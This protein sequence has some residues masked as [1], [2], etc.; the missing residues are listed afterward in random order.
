[1]LLWGVN[2]GPPLKLQPITGVEAFLKRLLDL[3]GQATDPRVQGIDGEWLP[4]TADPNAGYA[5]LF[6][7]ESQLPPHRVI[8]KLGDVQHHY[9][10]RTASNFDIASHIYLE[11]MFGRRPQPKLIVRVEN[12]NI[13]TTS[14]E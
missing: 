14:D 12:N 1:V 2:E 6:I 11:D 4:S 8:L 13:T 7:P 10:L 9:Y 3:A 5:A